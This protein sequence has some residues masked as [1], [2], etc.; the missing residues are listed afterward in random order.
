MFCLDRVQ[1]KCG[2]C[3]TK[4]ITL[5]DWERHTGC[6]AKK[7]KHS[8]K[9]KETMSPLEKWVSTTLNNMIS[10]GPIMNPMSAK[11]AAGFINFPCG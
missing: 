10:S 1:C 8:V 4:K 9:V 6:K 11:F 3:G 5:N 2:L 7:W